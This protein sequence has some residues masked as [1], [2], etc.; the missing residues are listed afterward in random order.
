MIAMKSTQAESQTVIS[1]KSPV[2]LESVLCT[3]ELNRRSSPLPD[4]EKE[5][6]ALVAL[7]RALADSPNTI[8]QRIV[9]TMLETFC[10]GSSGISLLT[11]DDGGERFY[12]PAIAGLWKFHIGGGTPRDFGPC[13]DVLDRN[14]PLLFKRFERRYTYFLPVTPPIEE[15]LLVPFYIE[16]KAVGTIWLIAHDDR[17]K[18]NAED[19]RQLVSLGSFASAAYQMVAYQEKAVSINEALVLG[20]LRQHELTE[21]SDS[22]NIELQREVTER[23]RAEKALQAEKYKAESANNAKSEFLANMSHEIRTPMNAV[24]GLSNLL[25]MSKD[26][27]KKQQEMVSTLQLSA[28]SL[29]GLI[30]D[31]LDIAKI[32][33]NSIDLEN[34]P[35]T[36]KEIISEIFSM[37]SLTAREKNIALDHVRSPLNDQLFLGDPLRIRQVLLNLVGNAIKFTDQG[38]VTISVTTSPHEEPRSAYVHIAVSDTGIGIAPNKL[39]GIFEKFTQGDTSITRKYGGTG[40]GLAISK[41]LAELMGGSIAIKS[42]LGKGSEF[43]LNLPLELASD[44]DAY[45]TI[46]EKNQIETSEVPLME[47]CILLAED[48]KPNVLVATYMLEALGYSFDIAINGKEA[49]EKIRTNKG[50]YLAVLMDVQMPDM[51]GFEV[52]KI[53]REEEKANGLPHLPIIAVTANAL[54]GDR[55]F[56][57]KSGMDEYISKPFEPRELANKLAAITKS[58]MVVL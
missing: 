31:L 16:G 28:Q 55:E 17:R 32:E 3:E 14:T 2:L 30:N 46:A 43:T 39:E 18:F 36:L 26:L 41:N 45:S 19:L 11:K 35:F 29:L 49:L 12:W 9:E 25:A 4:Y 23:K 20:S 22:L 6:R 54:Q 52:T 42:Q 15:C 1:G 44:T 5:N 51:D 56:C 38:G 37:L 53:I 40:L 8:L 47:G 27:P 33:T 57:L 7:T 10:V 48:N 13:G 21:V 50:K 34:I 24:L 58:F